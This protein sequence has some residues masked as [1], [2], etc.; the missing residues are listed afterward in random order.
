M[1][2]KRSFKF[3][4]L[5]SLLS[6]LLQST[7]FI[8]SIMPAYNIFEGLGE[9]QGHTQWNS[10]FTHLFKEWMLYFW[11]DIPTFLKIVLTDLSHVRSW[12]YCKTME[13]PDGIKAL[14]QSDGLLWGQTLWSF[15]WTLGFFCRIFFVYFTVV[16][17]KVQIQSMAWR[18]HS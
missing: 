16:W 3:L 4:I 2:G 9:I 5:L 11:T 15:W 17:G 13:N 6:E 18:C 14:G 10:L 8:I 12:V 1:G 7:S